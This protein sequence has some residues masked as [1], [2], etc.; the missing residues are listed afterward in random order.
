MP[1]SS[2]SADSSV[3]DLALA[4]EI[5]T[6]YNKRRVACGLAEYSVAEGDDC[7][8]FF[9]ALQSGIESMITYFGDADAA[10]AGQSALPT[11]YASTD[12]GMTDLGLTSAGYWRRLPQDVQSSLGWQNYGESCYS[13][14]KVQNGD[15]MGPWLWQDLMTALS[16]LTRMVKT[17]DAYDS[18]HDGYSRSVDVTDPP[19]TPTW[20]GVGSPD[21]TIKTDGAYAFISVDKRRNK[22]DQDTVNAQFCNLRETGS[23]IPVSGSASC[24][25]NIVSRIQ[26]NAVNS[27]FPTITGLTSD[28]IG[29]T[30]VYAATK[31]DEA[32]TAYA[33]VFKSPEAFTFTWADITAVLPWS[34]CVNDAVWYGKFFQFDAH[35]LVLDYD[36][37]D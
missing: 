18:F 8:S 19:S 28:L 7:Y 37:A 9:H 2:I 32:N 20:E 12:A 11:K 17:C 15:I 21:L 35:C 13:Y 3:Q 10:L 33:W 29:K 27:T 23:Y 16:G 34:D 24:A 36:F 1:F 5:V 30:V 31:N 14:G 26:S 6:A 25:A 4:Q 22:Y